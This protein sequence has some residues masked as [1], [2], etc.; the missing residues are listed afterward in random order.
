M[1][2]LS[3]RRAAAAVVNLQK[4]ILEC[5]FFVPGF[6]C[7][8]FELG[9]WRSARSNTVD[10]I[11]LIRN[12]P[13]NGQITPFPRF[14]PSFKKSFLFRAITNFNHFRRVFELDSFTFKQLRQ[15]ISL[16]DFDCIVV[17]SFR[18]C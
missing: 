9:R 12:F 7:F 1:V 16:F 13:T 10:D 18:R 6:F 2:P 11:I 17:L 4:Y 8:V 15:V 5:N 14:S 3:S